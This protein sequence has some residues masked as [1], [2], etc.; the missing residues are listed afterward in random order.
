MAVSMFNLDISREAWLAILIAAYVLLAFRIAVHARRCGKGLWRWFFIT[1]F[2]TAIP[3]AVMFILNS[4]RPAHK[5]QQGQEPPEEAARPEIPQPKSLPQRTG[6]SRCG[7][8]GKLINK[9]GLI[10]SGDGLKL[11]P[12]CRLPFDEVFHA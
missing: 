7:Q 12:N 11:C 1:L 4:R 8:C 2:F 6:P 3:A 5:R 9:A 10:D